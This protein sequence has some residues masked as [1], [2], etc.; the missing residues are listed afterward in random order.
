MFRACAWSRA[1]HNCHCCG[2]PRCYRCC[3]SHWDTLR[4]RQGGSRGRLG[5]QGRDDGILGGTRRMRSLQQKEHIPSRSLIKIGNPKRKLI[6]QPSIFRG[7][8]KLPG[9]NC[10]N[11]TD[12]FEF[13]LYLNLIFIHNFHP[14]NQGRA[15]YLW[16]RLTSKKL[17]GFLSSK[18]LKI[19]N[20]HFRSFQYSILELCHE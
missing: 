3:F 9:G 5:R 20:K 8:V 12:I 6:F 15:R 11:I 2:S 14:F 1:C 18:Y 4:H 10:Y 17:F 19:L 13:V 7:Y 16:F